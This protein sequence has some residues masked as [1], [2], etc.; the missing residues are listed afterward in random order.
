MDC[1]ISRHFVI[2]AKFIGATQN[3]RDAPIPNF[4]SDTD[5]DTPFSVSADTEYRSDTA[6]TEY[7]TY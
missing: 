4:I 1:A 2:T 6:D 3:L 7:R 5:S